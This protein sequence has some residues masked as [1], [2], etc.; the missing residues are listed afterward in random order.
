MM[1]R[2]CAFAGFALISAASSLAP[3][4]GQKEKVVED[5]KLT[6]KLTAEDPRDKK[7][8][9][10]FKVQT[11][12]MTKGNLYTIDMRSKQL[13]SYLR[14]EDQAGAALAEDDDSGG[15]LDARIVFS[16]TKDGEYKVICTALGNGFGD[17]T[18]TIT[19]TLNVARSSSAHQELIGKAAPHFA[20]DFAVNGPAPR[21]ADFKGKV[22]VL[23]FTDLRLD[24]CV[25]AVPRWREWRKTFADKDFEILAVTFYNFEIGQQ[26]GFDKDTGKLVKV[27]TATKQSEQTALTDFA[28]HHK[29]G[30]QLM[31]LSRETAL[32]TFNAYA[33]N[34]LPQV[35]LIDREG[36]IRFIWVGDEKS[37]APVTAEIAKILQG[38]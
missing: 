28:T 15:D 14:L 21:L 37:A 13:D 11:I 29:V 17:Y 33:V 27:P 20:G 9:S 7:M 19:H 6:G 22:V 38:K 18:L 36:V 16:C 25:A 31:A 23:E 4:D 32:R 10:A 35:V 3:A 26:I 12:K 5:V 30:H 8:G 24:A 34:G 2:F 1:T